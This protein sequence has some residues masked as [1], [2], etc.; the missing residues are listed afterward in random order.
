MT[1]GLLELGV[2]LRLR[3]G[4]TVMLHMKACLLIPDIQLSSPSLAFGPVQTGKCKVNAS[5]V[6]THVPTPSAP[7]AFQKPTSGKV[8]KLSFQTFITHAC[9][10]AALAWRDTPGT[11]VLYAWKDTVTLLKA[12]HLP[13]SDLL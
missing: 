12:L 6:L 10:G 9:C 11:A 2:P 8:R 1:R 4:P 5:F 7:S 3:T 13:V